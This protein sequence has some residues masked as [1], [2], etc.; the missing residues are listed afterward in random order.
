ME[1]V[2]R[3]GRL[4]YTSASG[5]ATWKLIEN[6]FVDDC[7]FWGDK[8]IMGSFTDDNRLSPP[9]LSPGDSW[10]YLEPSLA[11]FQFPFA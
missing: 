10:V 11:K 9:H 1:E 7:I 2:T 8:S 6:Q 3:E 4:S 5:E